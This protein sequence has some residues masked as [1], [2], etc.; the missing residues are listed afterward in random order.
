[1]SI[2]KALEK[3]I[4]QNS[5]KKE[6]SEKE[7]DPLSLFIKQS[8]SLLERY[9][10]P[11]FLFLFAGLLCFG[12]S[13]FYLHWQN[14][15]NEK[16]AEILYQARKKLMEAEKKAGGDILSFDNNQNFFSQSKKGTYS[17]EMD[18]VAQEYIHL[19]KQNI[20]KPSGLLAIS[21][22]AHFL[23]EY[24]KKNEAMDLLKAGDPYKK[25]NL[26]GFLNS[27]QLGAYLLDQK[28]YDTAIKSFLFITTNEKAKWLW[29]E[30]LIKLGLAYEGQG[31]ITQAGS[32]YKQ[33]KGID[34]LSAQKATQY[35]NLLHLQQK[36]K[37]QNVSK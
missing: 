6:P 35:L 22:T 2:M 1:M 9:F 14:Q 26:T 10:K 4:M 12:L 36:I 13:L 34:S 7:R 33:A 11:F 20:K 23:Y 30:A 29:P 31:Q 32:A 28:E 3:T 8:Q 15:Q 17:P 5:N 16:V 25:E 27:F 19:I 21:Q 24:D 18:K 37:A